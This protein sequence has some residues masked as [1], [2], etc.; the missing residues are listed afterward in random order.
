MD[1][2]ISA[3]RASIKSSLDANIKSLQLQLDRAQSV[4]KKANASIASVPEE[5]KTT[6]NI[7]QQQ[8]KEPLYN[9]LLQK[10]EENAITLAI[11]DSNAKMIE[12]PF[13]VKQHH[14]KP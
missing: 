1:G 11:T 7:R 8:I 6:L 9:F 5:E 2:T 13:D 3:L 12:P 4:E 10:R 14:V